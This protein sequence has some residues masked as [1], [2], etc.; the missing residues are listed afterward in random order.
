MF[1]VSLHCDPNY[2]Y[3]FHS[4]FAHQVGAEE[5]TGATMHLPMPPKTTW[6]QYCHSLERAVG[7]V[8]EFE[9]E[10]V[11]VSLGLDTLDKDPCT[12][13]RAGFCL[14]GNDYVKMGVVL[15]K[16]LRELP[17]VFLQEGG[18]RMDAV[19]EAAGNVL[20]GFANNRATPR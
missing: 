17:T 19:A 8:N 7:A 4:G 14:A 6:S 2:D 12:F 11:V 20:L 10:A 13:R 5:G 3:P 15:A 9:A 1:V 18:Y 16:G